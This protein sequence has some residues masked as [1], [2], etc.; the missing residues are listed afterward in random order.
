M[1]RDTCRYPS[2]E[3]P[4][5]EEAQ[6]AFARQFCSPEC[7]LKYEDVM[8]GGRDAARSE[9]ADFGGGESTGVQDL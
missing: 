3:E 9:P 4:P 5:R 6:D 8:D 7:E 1:T 2:C